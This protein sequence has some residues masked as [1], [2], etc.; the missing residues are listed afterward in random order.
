M[1][2]F[3]KQGQKI[4]FKTLSNEGQSKSLVSRKKKAHESSIVRHA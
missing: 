3:N 2:F 4:S 1:N